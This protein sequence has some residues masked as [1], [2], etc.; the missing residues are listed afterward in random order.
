MS[1]EAD[2]TLAAGALTGDP[3]ASERSEA[4]TRGHH[5]DAETILAKAHMEMT[6]HASVEI[7]VDDLTIEQCSDVM[8]S[9]T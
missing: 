8:I 2:P 9:L 5:P 4:S 1:K 7:M 6:K 3:P